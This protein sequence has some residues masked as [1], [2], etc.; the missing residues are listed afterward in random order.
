MDNMILSPEKAKWHAM[1]PSGIGRRLLFP[2]NGDVLPTSPEVIA[3]MARWSALP[4]RYK[5]MFVGMTTGAAC[6]EL[7][8]ADAERITQSVA[9]VA[10]CLI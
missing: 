10:S 2:L 1:E 3:N 7:L 6:A 8:V 4:R 9:I 5:F